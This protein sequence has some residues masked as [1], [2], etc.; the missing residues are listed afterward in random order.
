MKVNNEELKLLDVSLSSFDDEAG[1][2]AAVGSTGDQGTT[3]TGADNSGDALH[4]DG[5]QGNDAGNAAGS[6]GSDQGTEDYDT[7]FEEM[8]KGEYKGAF[9]KRLQSNIDRRFKKTK[10]L[11]ESHSKLNGVIGLMSRKYGTTDV[12]EISKRLEQEHIEELAMEQGIPLDAAKNSYEQ[13]KKIK[14]FEAQAARVKQDQLISDLESQSMKLRDKY[15]GIDF[16][17]SIQDAAFVKTLASNGYNLESAYRLHYF[18]TIL[19]KTAKGVKEQIAT[20]VYTKSNRPA[21]NGTQEKQGFKFNHKPFAEM[22][23]DEMDEWAA[24]NR[25]K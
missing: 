8:I 6:D 12:E 14:E 3:G 2:A 21:E 17:E 13:E 7:K 19:E 9:E 10:E 20:N 16:E 22:S 24:A 1:A 5:N 25:K 15:P 4:N 18:D 23:K 11:E